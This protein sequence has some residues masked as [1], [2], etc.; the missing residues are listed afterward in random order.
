MESKWGTGEKV[1]IEKEGDKK[2]R[3]QENK[4]GKCALNC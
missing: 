4:E 1:R 3:K 2:N